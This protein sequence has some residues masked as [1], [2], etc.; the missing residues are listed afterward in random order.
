MRPLSQWHSQNSI[1]CEAGRREVCT[2][3]SL[4]NIL[5]NDLIK[6]NLV[7]HEGATTSNLQTKKL[8]K[9]NKMVSDV[10]PKANMS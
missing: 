7:L 10:P 9:K 2:C 3:P 8:I 5:K 4:D 1:P 6:E